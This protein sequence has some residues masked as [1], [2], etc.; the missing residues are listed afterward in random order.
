MICE[1]LYENEH[2]ERIECPNCMCDRLQSTLAEIEALA[3]WHC[4]EDADPLDTSPEDQAA[5]VNGLIVRL[6]RKARKA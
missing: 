3:S 1:H 2:G 5:H 6:C 4:D